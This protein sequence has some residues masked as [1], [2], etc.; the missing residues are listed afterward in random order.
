MACETWCVLY[1]GHDGEECQDMADIW[2][3]NDGNHHTEDEEEN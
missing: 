2:W 1:A 3:W